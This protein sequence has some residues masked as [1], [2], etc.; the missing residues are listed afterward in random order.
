MAFDSCSADRFDFVAKLAL[1]PEKVAAVVHR[2]LQAALSLVYLDLNTDICNHRCTFCDGF[3]RS[4][5]SANLPWNRLDTLMTEMEEMG[6]LSVVL[7]GDRGEPL[8]HPQIDRV[9][10]RFAESPVRYA[11]YS[12]GSVIAEELW[13]HLARAAFIRVS[14][15]AATPATHAAMHGYPVG[16]GDFDRVIANL[17][18]LAPMVPDLG[19]SFVLTPANA[20]EIA[21]AADRLLACG[22]RFI[23]YKPHYLPNY[24]LDT[25]WLRSAAPHVRREI[26]L[27]R[28]AWGARVVVN[29][30][31]DAVL[32]GGT[33][34]LHTGPRQCLT[35]ALRLVIS[36]HGCY[37]CTPY[38]G[39]AERRV[40]SILE[41][42]LREVVDSCAR[43]QLFDQ[44]CTR[45]CAY[46]DQNQALLKLDVGARA[47]V[48]R[49]TSAP[50][51]P[52]TP[53]DYFI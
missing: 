23:E 6:V 28:E 36:T 53:Q 1:F 45:M 50:A 41:Q 17:Q 47:P 34:P 22:A 38:R 39:E 43:R 9:L 42:S 52:T 32:G 14:V 11:L 2:D 29:N 44:C 3:Y 30:Q 18:R 31:I 4:L 25:L 49:P 12:N 16:R 8:L 21:A 35:S 40:G 5:T 13:P 10:A 24:T 37:T 48:A 51:N 33:Q 27:A 15:D 19:V 7:A 20:H 46:H 26:G